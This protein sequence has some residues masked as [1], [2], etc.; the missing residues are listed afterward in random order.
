MTKSATSRSN[1]LRR[2]WSSTQARWRAEHTTSYAIA[3]CYGLKVGER[4]DV[5]RASQ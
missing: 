1:A 3:A 4:L 2:T 5:L